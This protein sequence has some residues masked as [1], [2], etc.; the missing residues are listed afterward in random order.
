MEPQG[1]LQGHTKAKKNTHLEMNAS[2]YIEG[3]YQ[4]VKSTRSIFS[5]HVV[6]KQKIMQLLTR[7]NT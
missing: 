7:Y 3:K 4:K 1:E 5:T 6:T 2:G